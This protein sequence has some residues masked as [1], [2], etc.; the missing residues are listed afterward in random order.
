MIINHLVIQTL[1][2]ESH[3]NKIYSLPIYLAIMTVLG[4]IFM[5]NVEYNKS[6]IFSIISNYFNFST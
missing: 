1:E 6:K 3:L 4:A 5:F 2:I